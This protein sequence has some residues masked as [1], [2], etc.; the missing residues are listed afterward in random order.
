MKASR[1][2]LWR[3]STP[4]TPP[5]ATRGTH[6]AD[7]TSMRSR[8][9]WKARRS[10]LPLTRSERASRATRPAMPSPSGTRILGHS[11][12]STPIATRMP[13]SRRTGSRSI[14]EP[15]SAPVTPTAISSMRVNS[16]FESIVSSTDSTTSDRA[17][18]SSFLR[19]RVAVS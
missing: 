12:R 4:S 14:S 2:L 9:I 11:S 6:S 13:R 18:S 8:T 16:S 7:S 15:P 10:A 3:F 19:S 17:V 1:R 5:S